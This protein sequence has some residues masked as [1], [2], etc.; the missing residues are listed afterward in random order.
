MRKG[1][2]YKVDKPGDDPVLVERTQVREDGKKLSEQKTQ[3][4]K[5]APTPRGAKS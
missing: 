3:E 4:K 1:G 2:A 5:P